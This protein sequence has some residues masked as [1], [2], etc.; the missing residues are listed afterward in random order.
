MFTGQRQGVCGPVFLWYNNNN[1]NSIAAPQD[2]KDEM[3]SE[4]KSRFCASIGAVHA[5][6]YPLCEKHVRGACAAERSREVSCGRLWEEL[7]LLRWYLFS[8]NRREDFA[9][10]KF[11]RKF[12]GS[13][14]VLYKRIPTGQRRPEFEPFD[15]IFPCA[16]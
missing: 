11:R 7:S 5:P 15:V 13:V 12:R 14:A 10:E 2:R 3:K 6:R 9:A 4:R 8:P 16:Q 1:N